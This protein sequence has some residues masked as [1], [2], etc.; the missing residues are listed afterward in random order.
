M[1]TIALMLVLSV[2][3]SCFDR[4][5]EPLPPGPVTPE[6]QA[7]RQADCERRGGSFGSVGGSSLQVCFITPRDA[8]RSCTSNSDCEGVCL[9]RS[10]TCAPVIPLLGCNEVI[11]DGGTVATECVD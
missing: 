1:R 8:N 4:G 9:A 5:P 10:R 6:Q 2:L 7:D 3:G 11:L